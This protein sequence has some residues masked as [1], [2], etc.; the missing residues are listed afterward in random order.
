MCD[1]HLKQLYMGIHMGISLPYKETSQ[2]AEMH[3]HWW[4]ER[5]LFNLVS[6]LLM[7]RRRV[8]WDVQFN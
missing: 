3:S 4:L 5:V 6:V 2:F 8:L 7:I 1:E